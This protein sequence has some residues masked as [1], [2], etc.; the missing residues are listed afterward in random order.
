MRFKSPI[1]FVFL[2]CEKIRSKGNEVLI[3][4][5]QVPDGYCGIVEDIAII[6]GSSKSIVAL[7]VIDP[8][9]NQLS[10]P[11]IRQVQSTINGLAKRK[12]NEG[13]YISLI[14]EKSDARTKLSCYV[15]GFI[16]KP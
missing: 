4:G 15:S 1:P 3:K 8:K 6:K 13:E 11:I 16:Y 14:L 5:T 9:L 12:V 2:K 7:Y 10:H